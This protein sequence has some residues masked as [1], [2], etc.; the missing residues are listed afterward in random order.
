MKQTARIHIAR[1][2]TFRDAHGRTVTLGAEQIAALVESYDPVHKAPLVLGHPEMDAPAHGWVEGLSVGADGGLYAEVGDVTPDLAEAVKAGRYRNVSISWYPKGHQNSPKAD[3][4]VLR[5]V[6]ILGAT[7]PAI[8]GLTPLAFA[9]DEEG[10]VAIECSDQ[11]W[12]AWWAARRMFQ[13][14]RDS[15]IENGRSAEEAGRIIPDHD[16]DSIASAEREALDTGAQDAAPAFTDPTQQE[17]PP[18]TT[19]TKPTPPVDLA[20]R[21]AELDRREAAI[22]VREEAEAAREADARKAASVAF[23]DS[24]VAKGRLAPAARDIIAEAHR[25]LAADNAP[26][27]FSDGASRPPLAEFEKLFTGAAPVIDLAERSKADAS[28]PLEP[29]PDALTVR[30]KALQAGNPALTF[31]DAVRSAE[32]ELEGAGA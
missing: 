5:H 6:G 22:K 1:P 20:E 31:A 15:L 21:Q 18:V 32:A 9:A 24:L 13:R 3:T 7:V 28:T 8:R 4:D 25:R 17:E 26:V 10:V 23:A 2:G 29:N 27:S 14:I 16:L 30:A 19:G 12:S 11:Q